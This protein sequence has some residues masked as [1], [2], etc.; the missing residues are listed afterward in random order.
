MRLASLYSLPILHLDNVHWYDDWAERQWD[1]ENWIVRT[2]MQAN[3][4][5]WIIDGDYFSVASERFG[6]SELT[7]LL[8]YGRW[9]CWWSCFKRWREWRGR[10]RGNCPC[11]EKF[12]F[13]FQ[14]WILWDSRGKDIEY[15]HK[16]IMENGRGL[17]LRFKSRKELM[18]WLERLE[19]RKAAADEDAN[20][21]VVV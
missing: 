8:D 16:R 18:V 13:A 1:E 2:F 12:D 5:G 7:V 6:L 20:K 15:T 10:S 3:E 9:W 17:K 19:K 11:I 4:G 21:K 14:K